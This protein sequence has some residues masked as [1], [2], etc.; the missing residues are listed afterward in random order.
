M[1]DDPMGPRDRLIAAVGAVPHVI[2]GDKPTDAQTCAMKAYMLAEDWASTPTPWAGRRLT[3]QDYN[4]AIDWWNA[5]QEAEDEELAEA[6]AQAW[7]YPDT[8]EDES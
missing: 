1:N 7:H 4:A 3:A 6:V 5:R 2:A 8:G